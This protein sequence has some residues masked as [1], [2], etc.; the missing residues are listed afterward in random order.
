MRVREL[1]VESSRES[2]PFEALEGH[3]FVNLT[4][5]RESGEAVSTPV[6]FTIYEGRLYVTT[7]PGS[8]KMKRIRENP[9]VTLTPSNARGQRRGESVE[10]IGRIL[11]DG[12][13]P[14]R[15]TRAFREKYRLLLALLRLFVAREIGTLTLEV[16]PREGA[17][18]EVAR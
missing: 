14:E 16:S 18:R 4:T 13:A 9:R 11:A 15:A 2:H 3:D 7:D 5:F 1:L 6:W 10:G 8:G 12:E 17:S